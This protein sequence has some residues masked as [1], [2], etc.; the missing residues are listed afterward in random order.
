MSF[1][2]TNSQKILGKEY[3]TKD[4][5]QVIEDLVNIVV[6][7][8]EHLYGPGKTLR[9]AH[10]K[11]HGLLDVTFTVEP[12]LP[13]ELSVG[14]FA[15][16][17]T[18][19]AVLR[20][21][22]AS[23]E[24]GADIDRDVRGFAIKLLD[25]PGKKL[26]KDHPNPHTQDFLLISSP[27]FFAKNLKEF[28]EILFALTKGKPQL[29]KYALNPFDLPTFYR[30]I[31]DLIK[32]GNVL[33]IPYF[34]AVPY[35]FGAEEKAVKY[36]VAPINPG[37]T[38]IPHHPSPE[39]LRKNLAELLATQSVTYDFFVQFQEDAD[40][41]PIE[42]PTVE[43]TSE[44]H[45]V[46]QIH[47]PQQDFVALNRDR[48]HR[49]LSF[50]PWHALPA[51][52]PL[53]SFNR[54]R[55]RV[56][57]S[58][59]AHRH[60]QNRV[61]FKSIDPHKAPLAKRFN[62]LHAKQVTAATEASSTSNPT[63]PM[64]NKEI[65]ES[66][67]AAYQKQDLATVMSLMADDAVWFTQGDPKQIP[68]AGTYTGKAEITGYFELES[69]LI[70]PVSFTPTGLVGGIDEATQVFMAQEKV[71]VIKTGKY[72]ETLFSLVISLKDGKVI[73]VE[74][75]MDT[76]AVANAFA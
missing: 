23:A 28:A 53:G 66:M 45:K 22:N 68:Y 38:S 40:R 21:S 63:N 71:L 1:P 20:V 69:K 33:E 31:K 27:T 41:M 24:A 56:Y 6:G 59:V 65:V 74:S 2:S 42:D 3:P 58:S 60:G 18:Y 34:S 35:R 54:A 76:L 8:M 46:A 73:R 49:E 44:F 29:L 30:A 48:Y 19:P 12:N 32:V 67:L 10:P 57:P 25:V 75:L 64:K 15:T 50:N 62:S 61:T 43:W 36:K 37:K 5:N 7:H 70:K 14:I 4:E 72:Y 52:Q 13:P 47:I 55:K 16:P 39:Y 9:Q 17:H 51:H 11:A 26:I